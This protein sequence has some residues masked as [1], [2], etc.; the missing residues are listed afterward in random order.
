MFTTTMS[1]DEM[2]EEA[3]RDYREIYSR[4]ILESKDCLR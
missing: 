2:V 3:R 4:N 1:L